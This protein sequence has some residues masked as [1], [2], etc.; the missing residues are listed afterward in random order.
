MRDAFGGDLGSFP[1]AT[2]FLA[3]HN[4]LSPEF[5][6]GGVRRPLLAFLGIAHTWCL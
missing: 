6:G 3:V 5:L 1:V 2:P 4:C